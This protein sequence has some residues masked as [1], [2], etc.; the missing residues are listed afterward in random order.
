MYSFAA[1]VATRNVEILHVALVHMVDPLS[2]PLLTFQ[3]IDWFSVNPIMVCPFPTRMV[4]EDLL[5]AVP[6]AVYS[7]AGLVFRDLRHLMM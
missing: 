1:L 7:V 2:I 3:S 6:E 5:M 4:V